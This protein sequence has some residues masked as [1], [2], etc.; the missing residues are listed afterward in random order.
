M[1]VPAAAPPDLA[2]AL[3]GVEGWLEL[4]EARALYDQVATH[5]A[6]RPLTVVEIGSWKGRSTIAMALALEA[7]GPGSGTVHAIDPHTGSREHREQLGEVDTFAEFEANLERAGVRHR[8]E[9]VRAFSHEA[10]SRF[11]PGSI[12]VL[13]VDGSHEYEDVKRDIRD[14]LPRLAARANVA[15]NDPWWT[16]VFRALQEDVIRGSAAFRNPRFVEN[17]L[18][19]E[20]H[21]DAPATL[22]DRLRGVTFRAE[23]AAR[24]AHLRWLRRS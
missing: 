18:L 9:P 21:R 6:D 7:R 3:E 23:Y 16:G 15:F 11:A 20:Q 12:D 8:V 5:P 10:V 22:A 24:L 4:A 17:T 14:Y 19:Y 1:P 2:R 13:F